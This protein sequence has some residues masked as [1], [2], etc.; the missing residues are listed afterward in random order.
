MNNSFQE[1]INEKSD[2]ELINIL[3]RSG[4]YQPEFVELVKK[5]LVNVRN[6]QSY[7]DF[8]QSK[9]DEELIDFFNQSEEYPEKYI[10]LVKKELNE[11]S[12][13]YVTEKQTP[14]HF[15][16]QTNCLGQHLQRNPHKKTVPDS[17]KAEMEVA[18]QIYN[19]AANLLFKEKQSRDDVI[20][21]LIKCRKC[22]NCD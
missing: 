15:M 9:S 10:A 6:I 1:V 22:R 4:E 20:N 3:F 2:D 13:S 7:E 5:E 19:F 11:R 14:V 17:E 18:K 16:D 12:I 8:F 21:A